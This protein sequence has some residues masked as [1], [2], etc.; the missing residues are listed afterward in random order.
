MRLHEAAID[1]FRYSLYQDKEDVMQ[2]PFGAMVEDASRGD[3]QEAVDILVEACSANVSSCGT[4]CVWCTSMVAS[5][6]NPAEEDG[7]K[8]PAACVA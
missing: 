5:C 6:A 7:T 4:C 1:V 3:T 2:R 8:C